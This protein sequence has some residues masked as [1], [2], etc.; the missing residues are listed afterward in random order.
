LSTQELIENIFTKNIY[1]EEEVLGVRNDEDKSEIMH[2]LSDR[3]VRNILKD[4]ISFLHIKKLSDFT[5]KHVVNILFKEFAN[6]WISFAIDI[7]D[8]TKEEALVELQKR[9]RVKYLHDISDEY[10]K[11]YKDYIYEE[12]ANTFIDLLASINQSSDKVRLVNAVINSEL[13][14]NRSLIGINSFNQL[15]R[16]VI[17]AKNLKNAE[18]SA[19]QIKLSDIL[20]KLDSNTTSDDK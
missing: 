16:R 5:L 13:I 3:I 1:F 8:Y 15:H 14:A 2:I 10:Y 18:V 20:L 7:L 11:V 4:H 12:I 19:S 9:N 17:S 6:E